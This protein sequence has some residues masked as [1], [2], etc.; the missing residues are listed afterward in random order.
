MGNKQEQLSA[1]MDDAS[2]DVKTLHALLE[3]RGLQA[4]YS[5]YRLI[6]DVMRGDVRGPVQ[7]DLASRIALALDDEPTVLAPKAKRGSLWSRRLAPS[8]KPFMRQSAQWAVAASVAAI[9]VVS[10]QHV[11]QAASTD[12]TAPVSVLTT[13]P[14]GG[15]AA[16]VSLSTAPVPTSSAAAQAAAMEQRARLNAYL[17]DHQQQ[18]RFDGEKLQDEQIP[19]PQQ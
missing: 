5:R 8:I 19:Q 14:I 4:S 3:D 1:W 15:V 16:P 2:A 10:V 17:K 9:A 13:R 18:V 6:G 11:N 7:V 12:P